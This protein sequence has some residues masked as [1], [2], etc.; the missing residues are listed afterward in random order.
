MLSTLALVSTV[1]EAD[2][3]EANPFVAFEQALTATLTSFKGWPLQPVAQVADCVMDAAK[4]VV[5]NNRTLNK[6]PTRNNI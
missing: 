3:E 6:K 2:A 1:T 4:P 5:Q